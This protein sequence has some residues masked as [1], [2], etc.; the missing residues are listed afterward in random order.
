MMNVHALLFE[1]AIV[2]E[3][4]PPARRFARRRYQRCFSSALAIAGSLHIGLMITGMGVQALL[5]RGG[6]EEE[7]TTFR[8]HVFDMPPS[9]E[10]RAPKD[11]GG[12][13]FTPTL[14]PEVP[15]DGIPI[16]VP[17][18]ETVF[19]TIR[20]GQQRVVSGVD[21]GPGLGTNDLRGFGVGEGDDF[22]SFEIV[23]EQPSVFVEW[24][25][26]MPEVIERPTPVY[27]ELARLAQIEGK[28][29]VRVTVGASGKV[30]D[31]IVVS[32]AHD[33]LDQAALEA[34]RC[35]V[36][37]PALQHGMPVATWVHLPFHFKLR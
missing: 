10:E 16:P 31:A 5:N 18:V 24:V 32:G 13:N 35:C 1:R 37:K 6:A 26:V 3:L 11:P 9:I 19:T 17:D 23:D 22:G 30:E 34:A 20:D 14:V 33:L 21:G 29:V 2:D 4:G 8:R 28:V 15:P 25:E 36:F 7:A 12:I 27:P